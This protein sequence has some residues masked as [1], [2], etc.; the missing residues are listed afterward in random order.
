[1]H[2]LITCGSTLHLEPPF[3]GFQQSDGAVKTLSHNHLEIFREA[4]RIFQIFCML[5]ML[6]YFHLS[7]KAYQG[8]SV[9]S[10]RPITERNVFPLMALAACLSSPVKEKNTARPWFSFSNKVKA[11]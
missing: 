1:M 10:F 5:H 9:I 6:D 8:P 4:L 7:N 11:Y 2:Y 3:C